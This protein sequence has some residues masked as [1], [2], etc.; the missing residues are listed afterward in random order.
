MNL[1]PLIHLYLIPGARVAYPVVAQ[2]LAQVTRGHRRGLKAAPS[3]LAKA[4]T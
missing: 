4:H 2:W 3:A 1:Y